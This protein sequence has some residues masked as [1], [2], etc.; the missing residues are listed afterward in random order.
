MVDVNRLDYSDKSFKRTGHHFYAVAN[1]HIEVDDFVLEAKTFDF[2]V[3]EGPRLTVGAYK[4]RNA[5]SV[6]QDEPQLRR[7]N[8][9]DEHVAGHYLGFV[10]VHTAVAF[11][12]QRFGGDLHVK[13][14]VLPVVVFNKLFDALLD[15]RFVTG[16][17]VKYVPFCVVI[18]AHNQPALFGRQ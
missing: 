4:T 18:F 6:D 15:K 12:Y 1:N 14:D 2:V 10:C 9:L 7:V 13:D 11:L 3:F 8:H 16:I 17:G 5:A